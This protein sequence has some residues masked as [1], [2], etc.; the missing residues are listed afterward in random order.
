MRSYQF[1]MAD[2]DA[3]NME[4][5]LAEHGREM[6]LSPTIA[7]RGEAWP[8]LDLRQA[9]RR[10]LGISE[11]GRIGDILGAAERKAKVGRMTAAGIVTGTVRAL[12]KD[13]QNAYFLTERD[14]VRDAFLW[15][16]TTGGMEAFWPLYELVDEL[17]T[18]DLALD[19]EPPR[20]GD[21]A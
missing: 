5:E 16:T 19:W 10:T 20:A 3:E 1:E 6:G 14:D 13:A 12:V 17:R 8:A 11:A 9:G 2:L 4:G 15:V 7:V 21:W 18:G